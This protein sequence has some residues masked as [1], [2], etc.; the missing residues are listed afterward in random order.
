MKEMENRLQ[1][2]SELREEYLRAHE[3]YLADRAELGEVPEV[4][5]I[6]AGG[7]PDRV[8]CLHVLVGQSLA[9]G[10][11]V[12]PFGDEVLEL[13]GSWWTGDA[14]SVIVPDDSTHD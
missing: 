2:S 9:C 13:V 5:G 12:N 6:S 1:E 7:M 10:P 3:R 11:G 14:C 8:K 4:E